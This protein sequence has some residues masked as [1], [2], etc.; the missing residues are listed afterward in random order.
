MMLPAISLRS[1][2][3]GRMKSLLTD[4]SYHASDRIPSSRHVA[5]RNPFFSSSNAAHTVQLIQDSLE[6]GQYSPVK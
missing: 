3:T 1:L 4:F 6:T 5:Y 2:F